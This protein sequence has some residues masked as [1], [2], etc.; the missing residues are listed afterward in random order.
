[1]IY[2]ARGS[3]M[4]TRSWLVWCRVVAVLALASGC[5]NL[6]I[7]DGALH[8]SSTH[9]GPAPYVCSPV[10]EMCYRQLPPAID[11]AGGG[12]GGDEDGG[13]D[14]SGVVGGNGMVA[15]GMACLTDGD[16]QSAFCRDGVCCH[17]RC[18]GACMACA[19]T[20]TGLEN[21]TCGFA[22]SGSDPRNNCDDQSTANRCG[23]D[24]QCDGKGACRKASAGQAC[25]DP[26]CT[27]PHTFV[28]GGTCDGAGVCKAG[29]TMDC[30]TYGCAVTGCAK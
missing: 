25:S 22:R 2:T 20:Y 10:D 30:G 1:M 26:A 14:R 12:G 19:M 7:A 13:I 29:T 3:G 18:D 15:N 11:A 17:D 28:S 16:C 23:Q 24:G 5:R 9:R 6:Q 4:T 21:G 27:G 8:C